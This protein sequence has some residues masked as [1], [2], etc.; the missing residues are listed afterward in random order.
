MTANIYGKYIMKTG[1]D[2]ENHQ[3]RYM[4]VPY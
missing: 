4:R 1:N 2:R 3:N